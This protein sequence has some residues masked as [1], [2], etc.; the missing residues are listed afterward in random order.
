MQVAA[1]P[2]NVG[3][4]G[5]LRAI[6]HHL[7]A[8]DI[9]IVSG[10]IVSDISPGAVAANHGRH[11]A[12]VT[13]MLCAEPVSGPSESGG[14]GGKD[15][16]KKPD[17]YDIIGI[18][19]SRQFL[20]YIAT[21]IRL[22]KSILCAAGKMVIRSDLMDSH[23]YAF[24]RSVL[25]K[26]LDQKPT[27]RCLKRDVL[28]YLVR[29]QLHQRSDVFSDE[30]AVD[31]NGNGHGKS[32]MQ[33]NEAVLSQILSNSSL[34]SFHQVFESGLNSPKPTNAVFI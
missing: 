2:E 7:T 21:D 15:K 24:K 30:K 14:A 31:E 17:C 1:V 4:A 28:P 33:N 12:A 3:T 11:D 6:A 18:D 22:K 19:S 5:A 26:V 29:M 23:I 8:K 20:L 34:P 13:A 9:L 27:F 16:T 10:D 25:Q 32:N